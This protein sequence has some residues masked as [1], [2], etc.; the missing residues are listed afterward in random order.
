MYRFVTRSAAHFLVHNHLM[1]CVV[2]SRRTHATAMDST[3]QNQTIIDYILQG[4][5]YV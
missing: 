2:R 1:H 5:E 3:E 4:H